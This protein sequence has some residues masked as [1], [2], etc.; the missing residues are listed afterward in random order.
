MQKLM[1]ILNTMLGYKQEI[2]NDT[3]VFVFVILPTA[4][5]LC[6]KLVLLVLFLDMPKLYKY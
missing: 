5:F 6:I 1:T 4:V 3:K 2:L